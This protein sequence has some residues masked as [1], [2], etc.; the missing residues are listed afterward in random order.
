MWPVALLPLLA[1]LLPADAPAQNRGR[2]SIDSMRE[3]SLDEL[4]NVSVTS[5][6]KREENLLNSPASV[7]VISREDIRRSSATSIPELLRRVPGLHVARIN[8]NT[9]AISARGFS[10]QFSNKLTILLDGRTLFTPVFSGVDWDACDMLLEDI[11]RIEV[12]RGANVTLWGTNAVNGVINIVTRNASATRGLFLEAGGGNYNRGLASARVGTSM[13]DRGALR[14][15]GRWRDTSRLRTESGPEAFDGLRSA[16]WGFRSDW[17]LSG[18]DSLMASGEVLHARTEV[19]FLTPLPGSSGFHAAPFHLDTTRGN[20]TAKWRRELEGGSEMVVQGYYDYFD[21]SDFDHQEHLNTVDGEFRHSTYL[22]WRY[23][24]QWG[25]NYHLQMDNLPGR[26]VRFIPQRRHEHLLG[27]FAQNDIDIVPDRLLFTG[28]IRIDRSGYTGLAAQPTLRLSWL[29]TPKSFAWASFSR[30]VRIPSRTDTSLSLTA[31]AVP[32]PGPIPF[33]FIELHGNADFGNEQNIAFEIG[34]RR[35]VNQRLTLDFVTFANRYSNLAA[36]LTVAPVLDRSTPVPRL[37]VPL[38]NQNAGKAR[39]LGAEL[40]LHALLTRR[41]KLNVSWSHLE[42]DLASMDG[43]FQGSLAGRSRA[44]P[45]HLVSVGTG[46]DLGWKVEMDTTLYYA[47]AS[48]REPQIDLRPLPM[49]PPRWQWDF[50]LRRPLAAGWE[51]Q[52]SGENLLN[53]Q[54][55][56]FAGVQGEPSIFTRSL[57]VRLLWRWKGN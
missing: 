35:Q 53:S 36:F 25:F 41:A 22:N 34:Y 50:S 55:P 31:G 29:V 5:V 45:R 11:E 2:T 13:G 7:Y 21:R 4:S 37:V 32:V 15:Y 12:I 27:L 26:N 56:Q 48:S 30:V 54:T 43:T 9:W 14:L 39:S 51:I 57:T 16:L 17:R 1:A 18:R 28:G 47:S 23:H 42:F 24:F 3:M 8:G 40:S 19:P 38:R 33:A 20:F 6:S 52:A 49:I 10:T 44:T 46:I